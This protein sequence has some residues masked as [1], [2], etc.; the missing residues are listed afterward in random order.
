MKE[1]EFLDARERK[2]VNPKYLKLQDENPSLLLILRLLAQVKSGSVSAC[3]LRSVLQGRSITSLIDSGV[4]TEVILEFSVLCI[5]VSI[6]DSALQ[7]L[8][9]RVDVSGEI[10][11][12]LY[13]REVQLAVMK[14][15]AIELLSR[16][17]ANINL[18]GNT[19][20]AED[21]LIRARMFRAI[22][23]ANY[24]EGLTGDETM[25][26]GMLE[27]YAFAGDLDRI[28]I[29]CTAGRRPSIETIQ[30]ALEQA[31]RMQH[32]EVAEYLRSQWEQQTRPSYRDRIGLLKV[33]WRALIGDS[34]QCRD[35][36][37]EF[38]TW[39]LEGI[40]IIDEFHINGMD[41]IAIFCIF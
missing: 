41:D 14:A 25:I 28:K 38:L 40:K 34:D 24:L 27:A 13:R 31:V 16:M 11:R 12:L 4:N 1:T 10:V 39:L 18:A 37:V 5:D 9:A 26:I 32:L 15:D 3:T 33:L 21:L 30:S 22:R 6:F 35:P 36:S 17:I 23:C 8:E 20:L 29:T 19:P 7:C 2:L